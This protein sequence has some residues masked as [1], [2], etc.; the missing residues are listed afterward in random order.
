MSAFGRWDEQRFREVAGICSRSQSTWSE[1]LAPGAL[2]SPAGQQAKTWWTMT[3]N[4]YSEKC[5]RPLPGQ[6]VQREVF[7]N[8]PDNACSEKC[9]Q[10]HPWTMRAARS[11]PDPSLDNACS[12]K[13]SRP[14][15]SGFF[16]L[17]IGKPRQDQLVSKE[18]W[19]EKCEVDNF[20]EWVNIWEAERDRDRYWDTE[21]KIKG[22]ESR[23]EGRHLCKNGASP[24]DPSPTPAHWP[25]Q[26]AAGQTTV[27]GEVFVVT[28]KEAKRDLGLKPRAGSP[29]THSGPLFSL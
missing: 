11:I 15:P 14:L 16:C 22:K 4:A 18:C 20:Q 12:E 24:K 17:W 13:C 26:G 28:R 1:H 3:V 27:T 19:S 2:N 8:P 5:S 23:G 21:K 7:Q 9:S 25:W 6:R 29:G 10:T